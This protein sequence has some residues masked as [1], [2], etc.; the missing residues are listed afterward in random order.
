[1]LER[2][3]FTFKLRICGLNSLCLN[4][5]FFAN[6]YEML[7]EIKNTF[8]RKLRFETGTLSKCGSTSLVVLD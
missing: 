2:V 1:M 4:V 7:N 8:G 3:C 5:L 6:F